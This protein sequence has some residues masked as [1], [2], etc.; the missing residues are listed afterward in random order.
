MSNQDR[1]ASQ[2]IYSTIRTLRW[3][4]DTQRFN[5]VTESKANEPFLCVDTKKASGWA[6]ILLGVQFPQGGSLLTKAGKMI[7]TQKD[8]GQGEILR[9]TPIESYR[10]GVSSK[11]SLTEMEWQKHNSNMN[12]ATPSKTSRA[13]NSTDS[14]TSRETGAESN[15]SRVEFLRK[16]A[17]RALAKMR[18]MRKAKG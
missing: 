7:H 3:S 4:D 14:Q 12:S 18:E 15:S 10:R 1:I 9:S 16:D 6:P 2:S 11:G 8:L 17:A 5:W 13:G